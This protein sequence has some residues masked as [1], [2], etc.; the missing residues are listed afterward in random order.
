MASLEAFY[1]D[2][3]P[4]TPPKNCYPTWDNVMRFYLSRVWSHSVDGKGP[5]RTEV[6]PEQALKDL[7]VFCVG[8][9]ETGDGCPRSWIKVMELFKKDVLPIYQKYRKGDIKDEAFK[10]KNKKKKKPPMSP[11]KPTRKSSRV[12]SSASE[13]SETDLEVAQASSSSSTQ[14]SSAKVSTRGSAG[15][16]RYSYWMKDHGEKLFDILSLVSVQERLAVGKAF[17]SEFYEDQKDP[18]KRF[19]VIE[20]MRVRKEFIEEERSS[21]LTKARKYVRKVL[22]LG[23]VVHHHDQHIDDPHDEDQ[24]L[25]DS[26]FKTPTPD[27]IPSAT[28]QR[29]SAITRSTVVRSIQDQIDNVITLPNSTRTLVDTGSQTQ[30]LFLEDI[31]SCNMPRISTRKKSTKK[32]A[33][34]ATLVSPAYLQSGALMMSVA[35]MSSSQ[36]ILAMKIHDETVYKQTRYLPLRMNKKYKRKLKWLKK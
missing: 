35:T 22:A 17:D 18:E 13:D 24:E 2:S 5:R 16:S 4:W 15:P 34:Q 32:G 6:S 29:L 23:G 21:E 28:R 12:P 11:P 27:N 36:A 26:P 8:V 7:A 14:F 10:K 9:W 31:K 1:Q 33:K 20:T 25:P 30:E 19:L 3:S